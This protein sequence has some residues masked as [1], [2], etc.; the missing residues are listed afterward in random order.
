MFGDF[1]IASLL[2]TISD[3][4]FN[5]DALANAL[6]CTKD[7]YGVG[8]I[9][10]E[11]QRQYVVRSPKNTRSVIYVVVTKVPHASR[12]IAEVKIKETVASPSLS[13]EIASAALSCGG[14]LLTI[15]AAIL[16]TGAIPFTAGASSVMVALAV[17]GTVATATQCVLGVVRIIDITENGAEVSTWLDSQK[18]YSATSNILDFIS[19]ASAGAALKGVLITYR[20]MKAA[21]SLRASQWLRTLPREERVRITKEIIRNKNPGISNK[22]IKA[23][24]K[25]GKY[26]KR[27]PTDGIQKSIQ[28]Q[29]LNSLNSM[30]AF[31]GS[32]LWGVIN[33]PGNLVDTGEYVVGMMQPI[34][35]FE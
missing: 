3:V 31:S 4:D 32:A 16:G 21:S 25:V 34:E 18:W 33:S 6:D 5:F 35:V 7:L 10:S 15:G 13:K 12:E 1:K 22:E 29:L 30:S 19:V 11:D 20:T 9:Y 27:F 26:P 24:I 2:H 23:F 14:V 28:V 8:I 17:A